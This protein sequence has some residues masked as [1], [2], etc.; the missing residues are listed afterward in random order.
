ML[1]N[2]SKNSNKS[3]CFEISKIKQMFSIA[4]LNIEPKLYYLI[5]FNLNV[6]S[7]QKFEYNYNVLLNF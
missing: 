5:E 4:F 2:K 1:L 7:C 3:V 6:N